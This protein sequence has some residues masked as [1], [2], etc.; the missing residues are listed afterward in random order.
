MCRGLEANYTVVN[1]KAE[2]GI[3][4]M[5]QTM[6]QISIKEEDR[7][8]FWKTVSALAQH[9]RGKRGDPSPFLAIHVSNIII[10]TVIAMAAAV[11]NNDQECIARLQARAKGAP[12]TFSPPPGREHIRFYINTTKKAAFWSALT[13][14]ANRVLEMRGGRSP[15][16]YVSLSALITGVFLELG[17]YS[18]APDEQVT[19]PLAMGRLLTITIPEVR[20]PVFWHMLI[21]LASSKSVLED[22]HNPFKRIDRSQ[23]VIDLVIAVAQVQQTGDTQPLLA[24]TGIP[25]QQ[26]DPVSVRP[27]TLVLY[28]SEKN[29][30]PFWDALTALG[31]YALNKQGSDNPFRGISASA[32]IIDVILAVGEALESNDLKRLSGLVNV[33][34]PALP[35]P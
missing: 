3:T 14:L 20:R 12:T 6:R 15:F 33:E 26:P 16:E 10:D 29:R 27:P 9:E 18:L 17:G 4:V 22:Q 28:I 7:Q 19:S 24:L 30:V 35:L 2:K 31:T 32:L 5:P 11:K 25:L 1:L 21:T 23:L 13:M 8:L 34:E